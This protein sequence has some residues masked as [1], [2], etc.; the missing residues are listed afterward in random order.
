[1]GIIF[2]LQK[3]GAQTKKESIAATIASQFFFKDLLLHLMREGFHFFTFPTKSQFHTPA[4]RRSFFSP[5]AA[6]KKS[7]HRRPL[8]L[9]SHD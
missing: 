4:I 2:F 1:M 8:L 5:L 6:P 3:N 7:A 9:H